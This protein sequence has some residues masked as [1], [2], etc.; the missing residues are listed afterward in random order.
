MECHCQISWFL[1]E[2][3]VE[4]IEKI[5]SWFLLLV[6]RLSSDVLQISGSRHGAPYDVDVRKPQGLPRPVDDFTK[7]RETVEHVHDL[8]QK[9]IAGTINASRHNFRRA[10]KKPSTVRSSC[11]VHSFHCVCGGSSLAPPSIPEE[12]S[13]LLY[14]LSSS[15]ARIIIISVENRRRRTCANREPA[16]RDPCAALVVLLS[17]PI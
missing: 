8:L 15:S 9:Q 12:G 11:F 16:Q 6:I 2:W 10:T 5:P 1:Y 17:P 14:N 13:T 3:D 4:K 7:V